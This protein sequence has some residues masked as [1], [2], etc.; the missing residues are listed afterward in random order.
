MAMRPSGK[1]E[2]S[3]SDPLAARPLHPLA[4]L[5]WLVPKPASRVASGKKMSHNARGGKG[6][7]RCAARVAMLW[8]LVLFKG[9]SIADYKDIMM[10]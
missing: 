10:S 8:V 7:V 9:A 2:Q 5:Q 6:D 4:R 1:G 3:L